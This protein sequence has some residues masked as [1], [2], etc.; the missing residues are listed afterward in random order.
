MPSLRDRR[1]RVAAALALLGCG[2]WLGGCNAADQARQ[3]MEAG[4]P[5]RAVSLYERAIRH[6][7]ADAQL[8][9]ELGAARAE[10]GDLLA[11]RAGRALRDDREKAALEL[12]RDAAFYDPAQRPTEVRIRHDVARRHLQ[13]AEDDLA[14]D[15]FDPARREAQYAQSIAHDLAEAA[16]MVQRIDE[17]Q[18]RALADD[19]MSYAEIGALHAAMTL[20]QRAAALQPEDEEIASLP[21]KIDVMRRARTFAALLGA[22]RDELSTGKLTRFDRTLARLRGLDVQHDALAELIADADARRARFDATITEARAARDAG[23]FDKAQRLYTAACRIVTDREDIRAEWEACEIE[24]RLVFLLDAG[25]AALEEGRWED[26]TDYFT[27]AYALWPEEENQARIRQTQA[28][29]YRKAAYEALDGGDRL[30]AIRHLH[31]LQQLEN[32]EV[33]ARILWRLSEEHIEETLA[34]ARRLH[35]A[36]QTNEAIAI[37]DAALQIVE[38]QRLLDLRAELAGASHQPR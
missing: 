34:E 32:D 14:R 11:Q 16:A 20:A 27:L 33:T 13:R 2:L 35:E 19:A 8:A 3:A 29:F 15:A 6:Q 30:A 24:S 25:T 4:Q 21:G 12:A 28:A 26:A 18:A 17:T 7:P 10:A 36:G 38:D 31:A 5:L 22:A 9:A 1:R 23:D 37:I